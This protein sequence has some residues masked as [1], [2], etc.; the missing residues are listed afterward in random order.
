MELY[1]DL[2]SPGLMVCIFITHDNKCYFTLKTVKSLELKYL[3]KKPTTKPFSLGDCFA[4]SF[5]VWCA[6]PKT[7]YNSKNITHSMNLAFPRPSYQV[8][9]IG[10]LF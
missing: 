1:T 5:V 10:K 3:L 2:L 8:I 6:S 9:S 7:N 4:R